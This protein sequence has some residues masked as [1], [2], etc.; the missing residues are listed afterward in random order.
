[1]EKSLAELIQS[2]G[3][4]LWGYL[5][6]RAEYVLA[7][8][9]SKSKA[10]DLTSLDFVD[11]LL[12]SGYV[13]ISGEN[14]EL[15]KGDHWLCDP[16]EPTVPQPKKQ[17]NRQKQLERIA[18][19]AGYPNDYF[20][21]TGKY[22]AIFHN[23]IAEFDFDTIETIAYDNRGI[24]LQAILTRRVFKSLLTKFESESR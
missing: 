7:G 17:P 15:R 23:L 8:D 10:I 13:T 2:Q 4:G 9:I 21:N 12:H 16:P 19:L 20:L 11:L 1:M 14:L 24:G 18:E 6:I 3:N 5:V 22:R